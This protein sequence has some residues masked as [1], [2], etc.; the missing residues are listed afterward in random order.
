MNKITWLDLFNF[1]NERAND[2][3]NL[4]KFD[5]QAEV[6]VY[7]N[8]YGGLYSSNLIELYNFHNTQFCIEI[9]SGENNERS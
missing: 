7:D 5:W 4:G 6:K 2:F 3:K 8:Q 9:D 1:L